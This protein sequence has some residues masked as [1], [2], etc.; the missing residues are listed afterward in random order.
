MPHGSLYRSDLIHGRRDRAAAPRDAGGRT[1]AIR[2]RGCGH[3][4]AGVSLSS[5]KAAAP[6]PEVVV[7]RHSISMIS[8]VDATFH[9]V[10][11]SWVRLRAA[12]SIA[13]SSICSA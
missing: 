5:L 4:G 10:T 2:P 8:P 7:A 13:C 1:A 12:T 9:P 3:E 6:A 11:T